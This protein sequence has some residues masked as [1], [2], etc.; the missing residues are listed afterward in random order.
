MK[1]IEERIAAA[2]EAG[3]ALAQSLRMI[4]TAQAHGV[5]VT[6]DPKLVLENWDA[7]V[8]KIHLRRRRKP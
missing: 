2:I 3:E 8:S 1:I 6:I 4:Q 7:A 5:S